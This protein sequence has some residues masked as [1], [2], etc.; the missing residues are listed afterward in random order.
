[1]TTALQDPRT[2]PPAIDLNPPT[3]PMIDRQRDAVEIAQFILEANVRLVILHGA[4]DSGKTELV[5][6][7]VIPELRG[8]LEAS[9]RQVLYG[10]CSPTFPDVLEEDAGGV[11]FDDAL[12]SKNIL[13]VDSFDVLLDLPRDAQRAQLDQ[14]FARLLGPDVAAKLVLVVASRH[15]NS[16]YA[17]ASYDPDATRAV[18]ELRS[19]SVDE[20]L[21][22][23]VEMNAPE[24]IEY[25][26]A[27]LK[28]VGADCAK[29]AAAGWADTFDLVRLIHSRLVIRSRNAG[30]ASISVK[31]YEDLDGAGGILRAHLEDG[32][33]AID[34]DNPGDGT[35]ARLVLER[36]YEADRDRAAVEMDKLAARIG[37]T[38]LDLERVIALMSQPGGLVRQKAGGSLRVVPRQLLAIVREDVVGRERQLERLYRIITDNTR[39]WLQL[40]GLLSG[41]RF[42]EVHAAR[43][44]L[45]VTEDQARFLVHCA[46]LYESSATAGAARYW[47][48]RVSDEKDRLNL[49]LLSLMHGGTDARMRAAELLGQ[50]A[51]DEVRDSLCSVALSDSETKV[52][53]AAVNSLARMATPEVMHKILREVNSPQSPYRAAAVDALRI[54]RSSEIAAVLKRLV[55]DPHVEWPLREKAINVLSA[56]DVEESVD[57]LLDVALKDEDEEDREA[58]A[59][60]LRQ[61][62]PDALNQR[63]F[64]R[65]AS[66]V[67]LGRW[68]LAGTLGLSALF[69]FPAR[70]Q[71][72][73]GM[74]HG[75]TSRLLLAAVSV[76]GLLAVAPTL[77]KLRRRQIR[78]RSAPGIAAALV[79]AVNAYATFPL[80]HGLAHFA[81]GMRRRAAL[82]FGA[83]LLALVFINMVAPT[84][85]A[86]ISLGWMSYIWQW[87]GYLVLAG[88]YAYDVV[89]VLLGSIVLNE[90]TTLEQRRSSVYDEVFANPGAARLII[91]SLDKPPVAA[92][93]FAKRLLQRFGARMQ[94]VQL[95]TLLESGSPRSQPFVARALRES[96]TDETVHRL[97]TLWRTTG[98]RTL[99]ERVATILY[100]KPNE[101]SLEALARMRPELGRWQR[102][103]ARLARHVYA[104]RLW[105]RTLRYGLLAL[106]PA[107]GVLVYNGAMMVYN[108]AWSQ[109]VALRQPVSEAK[110]LSIIQFLGDVYPDESAAHLFALFH[111]DKAKL[112]VPVHAATAQALARLEARDVVAAPGEW[113]T[114]MGKWRPDLL[115]GVDRYAALLGGDSAA[116]PADSAV[117]SESTA[118]AL[119]GPLATSSTIDGAVADPLSPGE[120]EALIPSAAELDSLARA[121]LLDFAS[122]KDT[123]VADS[124]IRLLTRHAENVL[125][126][127]KDS[128]PRQARMI[129]R[130]VTTL[131]N[132]PFQRAIPILDTLLREQPPLGKLTNSSGMNKLS[133]ELER[134]AQRAYSVSLQ[135]ESLAD[136]KQL[137]QI[138][139]RVS[140]RDSIA[141]SSK[142]SSRVSL[143][144]S[145]VKQTL[146]HIQADLFERVSCDR[147]NDNKCDDKETALGFIAEHP[148][149]EYGY[150]DLL[151]HYAEESEYAAAAHVLDSLKRQHPHLVWPRKIL[152]EVYHENLALEDSTYFTKSYNEMRELR[153]LPAY[154]E[155]RRFGADDYRRV[156]IDHVEI[157]FSAR[158]YGETDSLARRALG[159]TPDGS[160]RQY[161]QL[162]DTRRLNAAVFSYMALAMRGDALGAA[163]RLDQLEAVI[164]TLPPDFMNNWAY[165]GTEH[166][167]GTSGAPP[168]LRDALLRLCKSGEWYSTAEA[169]AVIAENR[170]ALDAMG[171]L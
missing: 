120:L 98:D 46:L 153:Q 77:Q 19:M 29:L 42:E 169:A 88:T 81:S 13:V 118:P 22:S 101:C 131:G 41:P 164:R 156:E 74:I 136:S 34:A 8:V 80:V 7:W 4:A 62:G 111:D 129:A 39:D 144:D 23:L 162:F 132:L 161:D 11:R 1:M 63:I 102:I 87:T 54:F 112:T 2:E 124:A 37:V 103:R 71:W 85:G 16:V 61:V 113:R 49:L 43:R 115:R 44:F 89:V 147:N 12:R 65:L 165:P 21:T 70:Y 130:A 125:A 53:A 119:L 78:L 122:V 127:A 151:S 35:I 95:I 109:I 48:Q 51:A 158:R 36:L 15:L 139:R 157:T 94:R 66:D 38:R 167:I 84:F 133:E 57:A 10:E 104:T 148:L 141:L 60:A 5:T 69:V 96:K 28:L 20:Q 59:K 25:E 79:F 166:F 168:G 117:E 67:R 83:E 137:L 91:D 160:E 9:G 135:S 97:E 106:L 159:A 17:L 163:S 68:L 50:Y 121:V 150:R 24:R 123:T 76:V 143:R 47:L 72:A 116:T 110:K 128:D 99:R 3:T 126:P 154:A 14:L 105:P 170:R 27:T 171:G 138:L 146:S 108:P 152:A 86:T 140:L 33:E 58:A 31:D 6:R 40:G 75:R 52:R 73:I 145:S 55:N 26:P 32:L 90:A 134:T 107:V 100:G 114:T 45:T 142:D 92:L 149:G 56:L 93:P 155:L 30:H 82:I 18:R 64:D